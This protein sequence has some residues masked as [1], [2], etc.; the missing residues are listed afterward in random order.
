MGEGNNMFELELEA[1]IT[2]LLGASLP[3]DSCK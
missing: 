1:L 3:G 2:V